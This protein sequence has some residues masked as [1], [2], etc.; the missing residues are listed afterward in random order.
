VEKKLYEVRLQIHDFAVPSQFLKS[1]PLSDDIFPYFDISGYDSKNYERI[2]NSLI[3]SW[4]AYTFFSPQ[5]IVVKLRVS[6]ASGNKPVAARDYYNVLAVNKNVSHGGDQEGLLCG[7]DWCASIGPDT[8]SLG[9]KLGAQNF[10]LL[11][12]LGITFNN[13]MNE[14]L[15][16]FSW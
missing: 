6:D 3:C 10:S 8:V 12:A 4:A 15:V 2:A 1:S 16:N 5:L 7:M 9:C 14:W 13:E 11:L